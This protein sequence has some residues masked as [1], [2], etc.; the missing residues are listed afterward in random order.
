GIGHTGF[1]TFP[2]AMYFGD[3]LNEP[4]VPFDGNVRF[5]CESDTEAAVQCPV[6]YL[7]KQLGDKEDAVVGTAADVDVCGSEGM[8]PVR[9]KPDR[10]RGFLFR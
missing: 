6:I 9:R 2:W 3:K 5:L 8:G 10:G 1:R 4:P 7:G